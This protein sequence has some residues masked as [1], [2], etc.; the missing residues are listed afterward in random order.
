[1]GRHDP[2]GDGGRV[3][4]D[5]LATPAA[6]RD[7]LVGLAEGWLLWKAAC[8]RG[9]GLPVHWL[10]RLAAPQAAAAVDRLLEAEAAWEVAR[11]RALEVCR[12]ET[13]QLAPEPRK[14]FRRAIR[15][16]VRG[17][18][19]A[20]AGALAGQAGLF[21]AVAEAAAARDDASQRAEA[22]VAAARPHI[23]SALQ[24]IGRE[25]LL[26]EALVWQNRRALRE[27]VDVL[28]RTDRATDNAERRRHEIAL[29]NY[30]Q[31]YCAKNDTIGF[32]GPAGWAHF[33]DDGPALAMAPGP[34]LLAE[35]RLHFEYWAI[36]ALSELLSRDEALRP[37]LA[38]RLHPSVR[39]EGDGTL[40]LPGRPPLRLPPPIVRLLAACDGRRAAADI[41]AGL[42]AGRSPAFAS[43]D[44]ALRQLSGLAQPGIVIWNAAVPIIPPADRWLRRLLE[45]VRDPEPRARALAR[46]GALEKGRAAV[47]AARGDPDALDRAMAA[48]EETFRQVTGSTATRHAGRAYGGRTILYED[49]RR[50]VE[51][52][53]GPELRGRL[54]PPFALLLRGAQWYLHDI[55]RRFTAC[56]DQVF[57]RLSAGGAPVD[58]HAMVLNNAELW[59]RGAAIVDEAVDAH[60]ARWQSVL[61]CDEAAREVQFSVAE[62]REPV[63]AAFPETTL[64]WPGARYHSPDLMIAAESAEAVAAGRYRLV[65]GEFN[66]GVNRLA[67]PTLALLYPQPREITRF[68]DDDLQRPR[69]LMLAR[70]DS[71]GHRVTFDSTSP[72]DFHLTANDTPSWRAAGQVLPAGELVVERAPE[73]LVVRT[74]D[75]G[76]RFH[77]ADLYSIILGPRYWH[78]ISLLPARPHLPRVVFDD[79]VVARESWRFPCGDLAF[80]GAASPEQRF[81]GARR[82]KREANLPRW[83]FARFAFERKPVCVDFDSPVSLEAFAK[84]ARRGAEEGGEV[85]VSE[86]LPTP[87]QC[88]LADAAGNRYTSE[89]R[90]AALHPDIW[91]P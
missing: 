91:R 56:L 16:L 69:I 57:D 77:M 29:C 84:L 12:A 72:G 13:A 8:L 22:A 49:C 46:L 26:R 19:P 64:H 40:H 82:W 42:A 90:L 18:I 27:S 62:L 65:L 10:E 31:R 88:W 9:A 36:D 24:D 44:E 37:W 38:P 61:A 6:R 71:K 3:S 7:H 28:L 51:V 54:G 2:T 52:T 43:P 78:K 55:G 60:A 35:R 76:R 70:R 67:L 86:M 17:R 4:Q 50:D 23:L 39:L 1:M 34:A 81:I 80:A 89:L 59:H 48:L 83:V 79:L 33:A 25:P 5:A 74:R 41:A 47:E 87:E 75:G 45:Q 73:G 58:L 68:L 63:A 53:L 14:A 30:V 21:E 20:A 11:Q 66:A 85:A 32:F 15:A